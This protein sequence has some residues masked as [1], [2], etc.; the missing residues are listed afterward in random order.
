[1]EGGFFTYCVET[2]T[3]ETKSVEHAFILQTVPYTQQSIAALSSDSVLM[4]MFYSVV[5]GQ[6]RF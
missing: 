3:T 1:V 2:V 6:K 5:Q 4:I